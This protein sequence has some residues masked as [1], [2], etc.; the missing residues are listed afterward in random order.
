MPLVTSSRFASVTAAGTNWRDVARQVL[1]ALETKL[2]PKLQNDA[3]PYNLGFLYVTDALAADLPSLLDFLRSATSIQHWVGAVG[4]GVCGTGIDHI[5]D[6]AASIMVGAFP[7][8]SFQVFP[9]TDLTLEGAAEKLDPWLET[10][11]PMLMLV[12]GDPL[13]DSDP[14]LV[15]QELERLSG[16]FIV[17]GLSSSRQKHFTVADTVNSGGLDGVIF[18]S[19]IPVATTLTQGCA[20]LGP[21]HTLTRFEGSV[22]LELDGQNAFEVFSHDLKTMAASRHGHDI[23]KAKITETIFRDNMDDPELDPDIQNLFQGEVHVA[24]PV[25]GSDQNDYMVRNITALDP[26]SGHI[27]VAHTLEPGQHMMFVHRDNKTLQ[28]DLTRAL[29]DLCQRLTRENGVFLPQGAIY[30]SCIARAQSDFGP[31]LKSVAG[32]VDGELR[33]VR[34]ILGDIPLTGFYANGEISNRRLYGY[35]GVLILFL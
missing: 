23:A 28:T 22:V 20:P 19:D 13:A 5:D 33:M 4:L 3:S 10:H 27:A 24:F 25:A 32:R 31:E 18:S 1:A 35:T 6:A 30:I 26:D 8:N 12:H 2:Q 17:G 21:V 29:S 34:E 9:A 15:M 16:A 7:E 11:D 14:S